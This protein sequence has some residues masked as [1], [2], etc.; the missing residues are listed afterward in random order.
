MPEALPLPPSFERHSLSAF[1]SGGGGGENGN[2]WRR[3]H[4]KRGIR[5]FLW[6]QTIS[7]ATEILSQYHV[8]VM[9][10]AKKTEK[11]DTKIWQFS[12]KIDVQT[13]LSFE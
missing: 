13:Q 7:I 8:H 9:A 6:K 4:G 1:G 3:M 5:Q 11:S 10:G 12:P 2:Q